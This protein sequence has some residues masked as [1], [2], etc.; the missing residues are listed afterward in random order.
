VLIHGVGGGASS[1]EW[2]DNFEELA[3]EYPVYA[4][5]VLGFGKSERP[6]LS[7]S[8]EL[9]IELLV[10]FLEKVVARPACLVATSI[11]AGHAIQVAFRNPQLVERLILIQ[12]AGRNDI[13][14]SSGPN[15][16]GSKLYPLFRSTIVGQLLFSFVASRFNVASFIKGQLFFDKKLV[17]NEMLEQ[18]RIAAHQHGARYAPLAF[19]AGLLNAETIVTFSKLR[20]PVL[21][22]WGR[23]SRITPLKEAQKFMVQNKQAQLVVL[24]KARLGVN[25]EKADEFNRLVKD[26]MNEKPTSVQ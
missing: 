3:T 11:S 7:Y 10:E 24:D 22:V 19:F 4:Y 9:Y 8:A 6:D 17:N 15:L 16:T 23:N 1:Y 20:Q 21:L 2:S 5:D 18:Y 26:F 14:G 13:S 25:K 12:P